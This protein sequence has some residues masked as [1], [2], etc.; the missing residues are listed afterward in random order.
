LPPSAASV[1]EPGSENGKAAI[2]KQATKATP[3]VNLLL[4][5]PDLARLNLPHPLLRQGKKQP[6]LK[7][8]EQ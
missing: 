6:L 8:I 7:D 3:K 1:E 2:V 4:A 5:I